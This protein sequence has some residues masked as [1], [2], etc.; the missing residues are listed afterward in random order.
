MLEYGEKELSEYI[1]KLKSDMKR[2]HGG[3]SYDNEAALTETL[4]GLVNRKLMGLFIRLSG[5]RTAELVKLLKHFTV[6]VV[7]FKG[8]QSAQVCSGGVRLDEIDIANMESKLCHGLYFCGEVLDV[9]G[10]CG[11]YNLQWAWSSGYAAGQ[12]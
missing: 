11:G 9:D 5:G 10:C 1:D 4:T 6:E 8:T 3:S 2:I 7:D 12:S